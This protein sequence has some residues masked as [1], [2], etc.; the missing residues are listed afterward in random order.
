M[1]EQTGQPVCVVYADGGSAVADHPR[2]EHGGRDLSFNTNHF[3]VF[4]V[5]LQRSRHP[6][7]LLGNH[8]AGTQIDLCGRPGPVFRADTGAFNPDDAVTRGML[9]TVWDGWAELPGQLSD[10]HYHRRKGRR[11]LRAA[12]AEGGTGNIAEGTGEGLFSLTNR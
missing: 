1:H 11:L 10:P 2:P 8:W 4:G 5:G 12:Y 9:V 7:A 3:S 6:Y